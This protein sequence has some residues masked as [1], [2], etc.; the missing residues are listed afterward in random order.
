MNQ[1]EWKYLRD[2]HKELLDFTYY[3]NARG[4]QLSLKCN[5]DPNAVV[6]HHLRDTEE[7]RNY[8]DEH[9]ELWGH[10]LDG[11]FEYGKYVVFVTKKEH[12]DIH[13][14]SEETKKK[15]GHAS[16]S[17]WQD[18]DYHESHSGENSAWYGRHHTED[19]KKKVSE[20]RKSYFVNNTISDETRHKMSDSGKGKHSGENN[21]MFGKQSSLKGVPRSDEVKRKISES[22]RGFHHTEDSKKKMSESHKAN[23]SGQNAPWYGK[24]RSDDTKKKISCIISEISSKY[25]EYKSSGGTMTW[26]EYQHYVKQ[27]NLGLQDE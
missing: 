23:C 16:K 10:N 17:R 21:G 18:K 26:H 24:S 19:S 7:Q 3:N 27:L 8:N 11:T 4:I 22:K 25:K 1:K 9:Y 12:A 20:S 5:Q 15:L 13:R 14:M 6:I 2:N